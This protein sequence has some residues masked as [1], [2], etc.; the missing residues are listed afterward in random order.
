MFLNY[1]NESRNEII[2]YFIK[3]FISLVLILSITEV[4]KQNT[5]LGALIASLPI[6]S[7]ISIV[8]IYYETNDII[9]VIDFSNNILWLILPSLV[10][11]IILPILLK[12]EFHFLFSMFISISVTLFS[13]YLLIKYLHTTS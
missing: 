8:F 4:G 1:S 12:F 2:F 11:F 13:Y 6:V 3:L 7:I 10:F 5:L 9:K